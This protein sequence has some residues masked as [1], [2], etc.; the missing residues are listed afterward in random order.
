[1][2]GNPVDMDNYQLTDRKRYMLVKK[3]VEI[4]QT[5]SQGLKMS[6]LENEL[7]ME[8]KQFEMLRKLKPSVERLISIIKQK[9]GAGLVKR[10]LKQSRKLKTA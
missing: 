8:Y 6:S 2:I 9:Y 10:A 3:T 5:N 1:M 4:F 7:K